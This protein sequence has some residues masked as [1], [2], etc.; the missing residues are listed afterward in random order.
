MRFFNTPSH[1]HIKSYHT[2]FS[3]GNCGNQDERDHEYNRVWHIIISYILCSIFFYFLVFACVFPW[4][5]TIIRVGRRFF[6][7]SS[8]IINSVLRN[9]N[10]SIKMERASHLSRLVIYVVYNGSFTAIVYY[11]YK[12]I[13]FGLL[14]QQIPLGIIYHMMIYNGRN[15]KQCLQQTKN[16]FENDIKHNILSIVL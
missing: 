12:S 4:R 1:Q 6:H 11:Y 5:R 13:P 14:L 8:R 9:F 3:D 7:H 16:I 10:R 2:Y 15:I